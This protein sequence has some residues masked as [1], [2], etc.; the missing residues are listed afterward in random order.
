MNA[1][2]WRLTLAATALMALVMG[3]R[4]DFGLFVSPLNGATGIGLAG[5]SL[6]AATAQLGLVLGQPW[7]ARLAERYGTA[8]VIGLGAWWLAA[9]TEAVAWADSALGLALVLFAGALAAAAVGSNAL[10]VGVVGAGSLAGQLLLSPATQF[11]IEAHGW[12]AAIFATAALY[13]LALPLAR[14]F[15]AAAPKPGPPAALGDVLRQA[16]FWRIAG[17]FSVCGF[18]VGFLGMHMPGVIERCGLPQALAGVW[19]GLLGAAN[20]AGSLGAGLV[21]RRWP[22]A[23][24]LVVLF[25]VRAARVAVLLW[26][27]PTAV[28]MLGFAAAMGLS[29]MA[30]LPPISQLLSQHIGKERLGRLMGVVMLVHQVGS[31]AGIGL[32]GW[33]AAR[34]GGD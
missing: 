10:L 32:G 22:A 11:A 16:G 34:S 3:S 5:I 30:V 24:L 14:A 28:V 31:F 18:H 26:L 6:A 15:R 1:A 21:L 9:T 17:A 27:P 23:T 13:L 33:A 12:V 8:R 2:A 25:L 29:Y 19:L 20:I 4:S 7:A